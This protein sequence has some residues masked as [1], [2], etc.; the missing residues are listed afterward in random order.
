MTRVIAIPPFFIPG[1]TQ[2]APTT[3]A[4][5]LVNALGQSIAGLAPLHGI[6]GRKLIT[7]TDAEQLIELEVNA[8]IVPFSQWQVTVTSGLV[9]QRVVVT[10]EDWEGSSEEPPLSLADLLYPEG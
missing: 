3:V 4:F 5:E 6:A 2:I 10:L 8:D 7:A 1:T 9:Q